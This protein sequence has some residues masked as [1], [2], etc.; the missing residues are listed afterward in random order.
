[1]MVWH[2]LFF[3]FLNFFLVMCFVVYAVKKY[4]VSYIREK[5]ERD[6]KEQTALQDKVYDIKK[7]EQEL[8]LSVMREKKVYEQLR[9]NIAL[10]R[11]VVERTQ[12]KFLEQ[13]ELIV[14]HL[15]TQRQ[16]QRSKRDMYLQLTS[17]AKKVVMEVEKEVKKEY[18]KELLVRQFTQ[19]S[20]DKL[21]NEKSI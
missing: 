17:T 2:F 9:S 18:S 13:K 19:Y 8:L 4:L 14:A 21:Y 3:R 1:M 5:I 7:N 10:W 6:Y 11:V 15:Y 16:E 12:T 20:I